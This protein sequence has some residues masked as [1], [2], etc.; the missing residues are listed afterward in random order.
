MNGKTLVQR[1][2][3]AIKDDHERG[4]QGR[5]YSCTCGYDNDCSQ[6]MQDAKSRIEAL[7]A[8]LRK[9]AGGA[10]TGEEMFKERLGDRKSP[11]WFAVNV[12]QDSLAACH[13]TAERALE[14]E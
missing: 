5:Y 2:D 13:G 1:L 11:T 14:G 3:A 9:I 6:A 10:K 7:E 12:L 8:A 4:C